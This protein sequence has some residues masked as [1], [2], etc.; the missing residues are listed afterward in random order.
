MPF[1]SLSVLASLAC[2]SLLSACG[3]DNV[4]IALPRTAAMTQASLPAAPQAGAPVPTRLASARM[5]QPDC[6]ADG[7]KGLRIIDANAE[8]FRYQAMQRAGGPQS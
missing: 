2:A 3:G 6:A 7:C 8:A 1:R 4:Q 5:P